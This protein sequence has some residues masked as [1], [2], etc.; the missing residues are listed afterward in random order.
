MFAQGICVH[1][2]Q[3]NW[4]WAKASWCIRQIPLP[5]YVLWVKKLSIAPWCACAQPLSCVRLFATPWTIARQAPL[6]MG[7]LQARLLEWIATSFSRGIF[8]TQGSN[9]GLLHCKQILY[10]LSH[11]GSHRNSYIGRKGNEDN[12][13]ILGEKNLKTEHRQNTAETLESKHLYCSILPSDLFHNA[14]VT[15][16]SGFV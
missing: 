10:H 7:I 16:P 8:P 11:Q 15:T 14:C 9:P 13:N 12:Q 2:Q 5:I 1:C 3:P 6:S 4:S